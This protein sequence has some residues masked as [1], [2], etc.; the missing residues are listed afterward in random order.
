MNF[1]GSGSDVYM[2]GDKVHLFFW[3]YTLRKG[4][5]MTYFGQDIYN[6]L[7]YKLNDE[8][9]KVRVLQALAEQSLHPD[10]VVPAR[11]EDERDGYD[12]WGWSL[13]SS[14]LVADE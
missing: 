7:I 3:E 2:K 8:L 10:H 11:E 14:Q 4:E 12:R 6:L 9:P 5:Y 13:Y 1:T